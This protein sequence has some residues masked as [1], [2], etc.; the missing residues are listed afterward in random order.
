M[1]GK[2]EGKGEDE[3]AHPCTLYI[4]GFKVSVHSN[5]CG[6]CIQHHKTQW[7]QM[8]NMK[9][10]GDLG[11]TSKSCCPQ[12]P[13]TI[14]LVYRIAGIYSFFSRGRNQGLKIEGIQG[15]TRGFSIR[16]ARHLRIRRRW[17]W[18]GKCCQCK[19]CCYTHCSLHFLQE[20]VKKLYTNYTFCFSAWG[21]FVLI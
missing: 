10:L 19:L 3:D 15:R 14:A 12:S 20:N 1:S 8:E 16:R 5:E 2:G 4:F 7:L 13:G 21:T 18:F 6:V 9:N 17:R 11:F